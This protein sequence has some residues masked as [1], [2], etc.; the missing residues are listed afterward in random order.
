MKLVRLL[1]SSCSNTVIR[2]ILFAVPAVLIGII[3]GP[4][5]GNLL[6]PERWGSSAEGQKEAITLVSY[7]RSS[8]PSLIYIVL[9][10]CC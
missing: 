1:D 7:L 4:V 10:V 8:N 9:T 5:A 2:L 6:D 3:L